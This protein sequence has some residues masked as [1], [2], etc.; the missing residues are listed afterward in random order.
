MEPLSGKWKRCVAF[1][2]PRALTIKRLKNGTG[3][4]YEM[5]AVADKL[6][7]SFYTAFHIYHNRI[8]QKSDLC[9]Y[10]FSPQRQPLHKFRVLHYVDV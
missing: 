3:F 9:N 6:T 7:L 4:E 10:Y 8:K 5:A 2:K 1:Q